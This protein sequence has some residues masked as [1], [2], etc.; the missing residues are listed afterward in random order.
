MNK[1]RLK[2][3]VL[4]IL[5]VLLCVGL[6]ACGKD[7]VQEPSSVVTKDN[8]VA[9]SAG[10][11]IALPADFTAPVEAGTMGAQIKPEGGMAGAFTLIRNRTTDYFT[12]SGTLTLSVNASMFVSSGEAGGYEPKETKYQ[13]ASAALWKKGAN[14]AEFVATAYFKA[15]GT[16]QTAT[17][18]GLDPNAEY[19]L[20]FNYS[21]YGTYR[22][23]GT[24]DLAGVTA[25]ASASAN[26]SST[27][28]KK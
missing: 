15:D 28:P 5:A 1:G 3:A 27:P 13:E 21:D 17:F 14:A 26:A 2:R 12:Q 9:V 8:Q 25:A 7:E 10:G 19:R 20:A 11:N 16:T 24:F 6:A 18:T 23:T 4:P 22:M